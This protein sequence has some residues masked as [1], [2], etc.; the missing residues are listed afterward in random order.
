MLRLEKV[1]LCN[2]DS[3]AV[4]AAVGYMD[5][6]T[7]SSLRRAAEILN[8]CCFQQEGAACRVMQP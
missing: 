7:V 3:S 4:N 1:G 2:W 8:A 5:V 6:R